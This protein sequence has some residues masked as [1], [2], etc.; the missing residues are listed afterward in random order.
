VGQGAYKDFDFYDISLCIAKYDSDGNPVRYL[1]Y[2]SS[3][4]VTGL[5]IKSLSFDSENGMI[6]CAHTASGDTVNI[7]TCAFGWRDDIWPSGSTH[8]NARLDPDGKMAWYREYPY[9]I[10]PNKSIIGQ[11]DQVITV[12]S[13]GCAVSADSTF[14]SGCYGRADGIIIKYDRLG[15]ILWTNHI[16][17]KADDEIMDVSL[18]DNR[19]LTLTVAMGDTIGRYNGTALQ[20]GGQRCIYGGSSFVVRIGESGQLAWYHP[21][22]VCFTVRNDFQLAGSESHTLFGLNFQD[23]ADY[24]DVHF[25]VPAGI[26]NACI[27]KIDNN[28]NPVWSKLIGIGQYDNL[29]EKV[30]ADRSGNALVSGSWFTPMR[31]DQF[32]LPAA[33]GKY[34]CKLLNGASSAG[35]TEYSSA[36]GQLN[37]WPN[38][39]ATAI[40]VGSDLQ[41]ADARLS[42]YNSQGQELLNRP[43]AGNSTTIDIS[44]LPSGIYLIRLTGSRQTVTGRFVR[45]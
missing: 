26:N 35:Q 9:Y 30:M 1:K 45:L 28:G 39:A 44:T 22:K 20:A 41:D 4:A 7:D 23:T 5:I 31:I 33:R 8:F 16:G 24:S 10:V 27:V 34:L 37:I 36:S 19:E 15:N 12:G 2:K 17:S 40:T 11:D 42:L 3:N 38:P 43:A 32:E 21:I 29:F 6:L 13:Y 25:R 18:N 14:G